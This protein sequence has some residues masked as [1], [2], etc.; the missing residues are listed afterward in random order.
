MKTRVCKK[1]CVKFVDEKGYFRWIAKMERRRKYR[2]SAHSK[3]PRFFNPAKLTLA[4]SIWY[5]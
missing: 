4:V 1:D 2:I 3:R 5:T